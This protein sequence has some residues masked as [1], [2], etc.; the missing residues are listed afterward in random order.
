VNYNKQLPFDF[1]HRPSLSGDDFLIS[2]SN[3]EAVAWLD[4]WPDWPSPLLILYG[5]PGCGKTHLSHVFMASSG[6]VQLTPELIKD[7]GVASLLNS[8]QNFVIDDGK[9]NT[10]VH[11]SEVSLF[12]L[13]NDLALR[14][15]HMLIT[16][17]SHPVNWAFKLADLSSRFKAAQAIGIGM[18]DDNLIKAV[19]VKLFSDRQVRVEI[20]VID[21]ITTR[22]ERSFDAARNF[23]RFANELA[24]VEKKGITLALARQVLDDLKS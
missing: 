24:L 22:M 12:H 14:G 17:E 10:F 7:F 20:S 23:V 3:Q 2:P 15:G 18:P 9:I 6:A 16:A 1:E 5:P 21:Y 13:Y 8:Q 4:K 11:L 19:L